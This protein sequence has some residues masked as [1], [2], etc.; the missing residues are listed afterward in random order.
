LC[1]D[2]K[3]ITFRS[4]DQPPFACR[5]HLTKAFQAQLRDSVKRFRKY[6]SEGNFQGINA[7]KG[8]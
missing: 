8:I 4:P 3:N 7:V 1:E 2:D 6:F 5:N